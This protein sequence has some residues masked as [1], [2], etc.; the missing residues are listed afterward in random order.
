MH[1][2][3]PMMMLW[4]TAPTIMVKVTYII[5]PVVNAEISPVFF[6]GAKTSTWKPWQEMKSDSSQ[7]HAPKHR[8]GAT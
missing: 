8:I 6:S 1:F 2:A 4:T 3:W 5:S 7:P